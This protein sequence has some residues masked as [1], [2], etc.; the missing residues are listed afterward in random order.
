[1]PARKRGLNGTLIAVGSTSD[2]GPGIVGYYYRLY[3]NLKSNLEQ[4]KIDIAS[5]VVLGKLDGFRAGDFPAKSYII[6]Y[7]SFERDVRNS[8]I[9]TAYS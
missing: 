2:N 3:F 9:K 5:Y 1:M 7:I 4:W 8:A 6:G